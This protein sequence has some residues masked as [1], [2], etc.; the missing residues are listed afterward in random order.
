[1]KISRLLT[2]K[3]VAEIILRYKLD[4]TL[5]PKPEPALVLRALE[6]KQIIS[7]SEPTSVTSLLQR[8]DNEAALNEWQTFSM[9]MYASG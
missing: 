6:T 2:D 7:E 9:D 8:L 4:T 1:M 5:Q 3:D